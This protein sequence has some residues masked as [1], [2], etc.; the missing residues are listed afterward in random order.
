MRG[1]SPE[2]KPDRDEPAPPGQGAQ[3]RLGARPAHRVDDHVGA[4][5][6]DLLD[7]LLR[8]SVRVVDAGLGPLRCR[9]RAS[10]SAVDA[11]ASTRAPEQAAELDRG[12]A[13]P[14]RRRRA[15]PPTP[16]AGP[17]PRCAGR[18]RRCGGPPRRRPPMPGRRPG[19]PRAG[20]CAGH[21][22][23]LGEG[24]DQARPRS[25]GRPTASPSTPGPTARTVPANSLPGVKGTGTWTWYWSATTRTSGKLAAAADHV[26]HH[27]ALTGHRVGHLLHHHRGR[28]AR[29]AVQRAARIGPAQEL[30]TTCSR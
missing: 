8:F 24:P 12:Q 20:H 3:G 22:H 5:A 26:D 4:A 30:P 17:G 14:R 21:H 18:G 19:R 28:V 13:R 9:H 11:A 27:L 10:F 7:P 25:P 29:T 2:A 23:L 15:P 6:G 1:I 16:R